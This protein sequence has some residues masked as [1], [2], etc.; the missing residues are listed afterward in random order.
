VIDKF[1]VIWNATRPLED[2]FFESSPQ[3]TV[4]IHGYAY[5]YGS[6][7]DL[8]DFSSVFGVSIYDLI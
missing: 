5:M 1:V 2:L 6:D 7:K 4:H 3:D 8:A